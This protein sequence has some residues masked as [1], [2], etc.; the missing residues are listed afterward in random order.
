MP[1]EPIISD[2]GPRAMARERPATEGASLRIEGVGRHKLTERG[3][4]I[5]GCIREHREPSAGEPP[6]GS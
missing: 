5:L 4:R 1:R 3:P 2:A 6:P